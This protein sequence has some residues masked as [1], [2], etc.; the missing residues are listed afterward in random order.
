MPTVQ[1]R[2]RSQSLYDLISLKAQQHHRSL[3]QQTIAELEQALQPQAQGLLLRARRLQML[4]KLR[5]QA[6]SKPVVL[7]DQLER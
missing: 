4:H 1:I 3:T 5:I 7:D 2:E 6:P